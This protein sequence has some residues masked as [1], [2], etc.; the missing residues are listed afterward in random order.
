MWDDGPLVK[1]GFHMDQSCTCAG[2]AD[3]GRVDARQEVRRAVLSRAGRARG[4]RG[5]KAIIE[6]RLARRAT[7]THF[8]YRNEFQTPF[9]PMGAIA[10]KAVMGGIPGPEANASLAALKGLIESAQSLTTSAV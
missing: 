4:R 7:G 10:A 9:G 8:E 2:C 6:D 5:R 3:Q 1:V